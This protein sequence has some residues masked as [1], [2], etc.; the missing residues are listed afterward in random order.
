MI[1][2]T[3][4]TG[5]AWTGCVVLVLLS[6][7]HLR[8]HDGEAAPALDGGR[9]NGTVIQSKRRDN[10]WSGR[11]AAGDWGA[12]ARLIPFLLPPDSS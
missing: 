9:T 3:V 1:E 8:A 12:E 10:A 4:E 6:S 11:Q 7:G 2:H 5:I